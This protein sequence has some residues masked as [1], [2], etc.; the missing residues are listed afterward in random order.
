MRNSKFYHDVIFPKTKLAGRSYV[1]V[2]G[3]TL[4]EY[5][6]A[7]AGYPLYDWLMVPFPRGLDHEHDFW[8][9]RVPCSSMVWCK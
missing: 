4:R 7:D 6:L 9:N 3:T 1:C 5:L 2:D 8:N